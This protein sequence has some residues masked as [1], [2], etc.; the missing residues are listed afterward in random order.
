M[1][2]AKYISHTLSVILAFCL[3]LELVALSYILWL[4]FSYLFPIPSQKNAS[5]SSEWDA[6][7]ASRPGARRLCCQGIIRI[8]PLHLFNHQTVHL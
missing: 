6:L 8:S 1:S 4:S 7:C 3:F 2:A 5:A